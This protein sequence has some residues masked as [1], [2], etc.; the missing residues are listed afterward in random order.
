MMSAISTFWLGYENIG[1]GRLFRTDKLRHPLSKI[2]LCYTVMRNLRPEIRIKLLHLEINRDRS[3]S[4]D[5]WQASSFRVSIVDWYRS[6]GYKGFFRWDVS[7][8]NS[9]VL[10]L[11]RERTE[12]TSY[13]LLWLWTMQ[14]NLVGIVREMRRRKTAEN[15]SHIPS[16]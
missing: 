13:I 7:S 15:R 11:W 9:N 1:I 8:G 12:S 3:K 5:F 2:E 6:Y 16:L 4:N 14:Q 10:V